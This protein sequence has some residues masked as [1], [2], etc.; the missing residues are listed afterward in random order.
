MIRVFG[1]KIMSA[2]G[3]SDT[4]NLTQRN[5]SEQYDFEVFIFNIIGMLSY[6]IFRAI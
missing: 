5:N 6:C 2:S 4:D 3:G 1:C